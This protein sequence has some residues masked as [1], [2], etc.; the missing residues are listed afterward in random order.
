MDSPVRRPGEDHDGPPRRDRPN[1]IYD[2][3]EAALA[4][5]RLAPPQPCDN[6]YAMDYIA[7]HSLRETSKP[8]AAGWQWKFDPSIW[9]RFDMEGTPPSEMIKNVSCPLAIMRGEDSAIAVDTVWAYMQELLGP[10]VPFISI[11]HAHHHVML[12]QPLAFVSALRTLL[13]SWRS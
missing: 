6:H 13:E 10:G 1:K 12:D 8:D 5:F 3:L 7:R 4:R 2:S 9:R 11:P